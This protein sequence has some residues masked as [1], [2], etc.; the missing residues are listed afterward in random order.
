MSSLRELEVTKIEGGSYSEVSGGSD[1]QLV[2]KANN[3]NGIRIHWVSLVTDNTN[4]AQIEA[5]TGGSFTLEATNNAN[6]QIFEVN[7]FVP[8][9]IE[10]RAKSFGGGATV[11]TAYTVR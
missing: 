6:H 10:L 1:T 2:S 5:G 4:S 9:D 8:P 3:T 11:Q 7:F